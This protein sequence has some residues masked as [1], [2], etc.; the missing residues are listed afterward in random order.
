MKH[1]VVVWL[2]FESDALKD[3]PGAVIYDWILQTVWR[4]TIKKLQKKI[5]LQL[6]LKEDQ[7]LTLTSL[8]LL[9]LL[10]STKSET[11]RQIKV[12]GKLNIPI[13]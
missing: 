11:A 9:K 3:K 4:L 6:V 1:F 10:V 12:N 13:I 7:R 5:E 2:Q 8:Q